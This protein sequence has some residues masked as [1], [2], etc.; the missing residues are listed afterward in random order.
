MPDCREQEAVVTAKAPAFSERHLL[1]QS[2]YLQFL[3]LPLHF[4]NSLID[5][6][7]H[8]ILPVCGKAPVACG[9]LA[10]CIS[11]RYSSRPR[12]RL[13]VALLPG[14]GRAISGRTLVDPKG[15]QTACAHVIAGSKGL[16]RGLNETCR[17]TYST[18]QSFIPR[19][20]EGRRA[21][22]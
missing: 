17:H 14:I 21:R 20:T 2:A 19:R 22:Q 1:F 15:A 9:K 10:N 4:G 18:L 13:L 3:L 5:P 7:G 16:A 12:G 8:E 11:V 6:C